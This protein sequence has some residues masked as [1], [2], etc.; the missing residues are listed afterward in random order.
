MQM[1]VPHDEVDVTS[2]SA[3]VDRSLNPH[4]LDC[5]AVGLFVV[6][7]VGV[8]L[9]LLLLWTVSAWHI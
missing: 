3:E 9:L 2:S 8:L 4:S 1:I 5:S 7:V 6:V